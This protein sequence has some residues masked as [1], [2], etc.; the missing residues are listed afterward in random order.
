MTNLSSPVIPAAFAEEWVSVAMDVFPSILD[1]N[2]RPDESIFGSSRYPM[3]ASQHGAGCLCATG[4]TPK[5]V[6][7]V[8]RAS[9]AR[10]RDGIGS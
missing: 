8:R 6:R 2:A 9:G 4:L 3:K 1:V 7:H 5:V 10:R